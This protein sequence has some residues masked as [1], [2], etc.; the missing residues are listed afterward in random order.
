MLA[1]LPGVNAQ[2]IGRA[3]LI[4]LWFWAG[5][6]KLIIDFIKPDSLPG[7]TTD[8]IPNDLANS[9]RTD[10]YHWNTHNVGVAMGFVIAASEMMLGLLC[11]VRPA[12]WIVAIA[13]VFMH[14]TIIAWN[15]WVWHCNLLGWNISL[16]LAGLVLIL[17]LARW[18][19]IASLRKCSP[20]AGVAAVFLLLYPATYYFN[21][22]S[23]YLSYCVYVP[24]SPV[25]DSA[26]REKN[27]K[28]FCS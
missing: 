20:W 19:S 26:A 16:A 18:R 3:N 13:A 25:A 6:H 9:F 12:R 22:A 23:A 5:F 7:F 1:T 17:P 15:C 28:I 24:N 27:I 8:V 11:F 2:L 14:L 21:G 10:K 4:S